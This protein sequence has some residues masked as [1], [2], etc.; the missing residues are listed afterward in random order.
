MILGCQSEPC[1]KVATR[2]ERLGRRRLHAEHRRPNRTDARNCRNTPA[3]VIL[4]MPLH[5]LGLDLRQASL[6]RGI[7]VRLKAEEIPRH[8]RQAIVFEHAFDK[9]R[10]VLPAGGPD[11]TKLSGIALKALESCDLTLT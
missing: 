4:A 1:R 10:N 7:L 9:C 2:S 6:D 5:Q 8:F 3:D 11:D